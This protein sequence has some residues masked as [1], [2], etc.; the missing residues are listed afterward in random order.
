M[1]KLI[2]PECFVYLLVV[3]NKGCY[4]TP[5]LLYGCKIWTLNKEDIRRLEA[6][7]MWF[8]RKM[9]KM[10]CTEKVSNEKILERTIKVE[11]C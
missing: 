5:N 8:L 10:K 11:N 7:E 4:M 9:E 3:T 2:S 6:T 1:F